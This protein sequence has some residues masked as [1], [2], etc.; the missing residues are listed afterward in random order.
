MKHFGPYF[1]PDCKTKG[2]LFR[3]LNTLSWKQ[4]PETV[5]FILFFLG[6]KSVVKVGSMTFRGSSEQSQGDPKLGWIVNGS[7]FCHLGIR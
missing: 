3:V 6:K 2:Y 4:C 7:C 5:A 1:P